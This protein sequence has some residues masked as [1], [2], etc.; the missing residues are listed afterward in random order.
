M[1]GCERIQEFNLQVLLKI[2]SRGL[3]TQLKYHHKAKAEVLKES[4]S[5]Q[6]KV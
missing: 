2:Q 4:L 1:T 3:I 6:R 5:Y